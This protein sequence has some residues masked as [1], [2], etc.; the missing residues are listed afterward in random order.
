MLLRFRLWMTLFFLALMAISPS[1][2]QDVQGDVYVEASVDNANPYIGQQ[3]IYKFKLYDAVG[4]TN[5]LYQP[6][7][8]EGFWR[9]DI[10]VLAQTIEQINGRQYTV[11]TIATAL[12][13]TQSGE[14]TIKPS[15]VVLPETV[16]RAKTTLTANP[17]SFIVQALPTGQPIDFGGA[18]G[19]FNV[20]AALDHQS[21]NLGEPITLTLTVSGT[22]NVEQLSSP[23]EPQNW[24][25]T[26]TAGNYSSELQNGIIVGKRDYQIVF[27]PTTA[28]KQPLPP[29]TLSYFDPDTHTYRS[30]GT[31]PVDVQVLGNS[32][33][34]MSQSAPLPETS[35]KL[36]P[37]SGVIVNNSDLS[38]EVFSILVLVPLLVVLSSFGWQRTKTK[39]QKQQILIRQQRALQ[40]ATQQMK[41][42]T[43]S[44]TQTAYEQISQIIQ[45]Y[46]AD[47]LNIDLLGSNK[48][49][50]LALMNRAA[51]SQSAIG[52]MTMLIQQIDEGLFAPSIQEMP[53]SR[54]EEITKLLSN[55]DQQWVKQ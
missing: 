8:F 49:D 50:I 28:G 41:H 7:D 42:V 46:V 19:Q 40:M 20:S 14:T 30:V 45:K 52:L 38:V 11:T 25:S 5:P 16:F 47:K 10:G 2:A 12:Y 22:G 15:G 53:P 35:L 9:V 17:I 39:R 24:R 26:V 3:I 37:I 48:L 31:A 32:N 6:S 18:V 36:K 33:N 44:E 1:F 13:P 27:F 34:T 29:I 21:A 4:L 51:V 54:R 43:F 23:T 55:I